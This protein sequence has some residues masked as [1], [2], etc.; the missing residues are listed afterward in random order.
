[1]NLKCIKD[2]H[3]YYTVVLNV[4]LFDANII[5]LFDAKNEYILQNLQ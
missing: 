5:T 1:M 3:G 2:N 4:K